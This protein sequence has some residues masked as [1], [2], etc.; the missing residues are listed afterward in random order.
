VRITR[1]KNIEL[2]IRVVQEL[3]DHGLDVCFVISGPVAPHHPG[4]S[5]GYLEELKVL[6]AHL[7]VEQEVLFLADA[8]GFNLT[9]DEVAELYQLA[10]ILFF[11]SA[12][13]GFGLPILEAGLSRVPVVLSDI[14]IFREVGGDDVVLFELNDPPDTI[15]ASVMRLLQHPSSRLYRRILR[16]YRWDSIV[17]RKIMPLLDQPSPAELSDGFGER[18]EQERPT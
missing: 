4:R 11:P 1:R 18:G 14:P 16:D 2:G 3:K 9:S 13:E 5:R 7:H 10:D 8:L 17:D 12:Q 15:A 6:R